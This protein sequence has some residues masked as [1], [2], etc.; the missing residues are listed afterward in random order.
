MKRRFGEILNFNVFGPKFEVIFH[1]RSSFVEGCLALVGGFLPLKL[2][3]HLR[4]SLLEDA[5]YWRSSSTEVVFHWRSSSTS[6]SG[7][8]LPLEVVFN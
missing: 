2:L 3:F 8:F 6:S 5:F 4:S 1:L 7:G